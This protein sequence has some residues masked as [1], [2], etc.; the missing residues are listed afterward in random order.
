LTGLLYSLDETY[1]DSDSY[2]QQKK[3]L[4]ALPPEDPLP[5]DPLPRSAPEDPLPRSTPED[6]L[7]KIHSRRSSPEDPFS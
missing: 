6:P 2:E 5:E 4:E 1:Q 3:I 7:L